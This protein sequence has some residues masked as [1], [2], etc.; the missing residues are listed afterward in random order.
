[1]KRKHNNIIV[2]FLGL[3]LISIVIIKLI[4]KHNDSYWRCIKA[5]SL[6]GLFEYTYF[7]QNSEYS[8]TIKKMIIDSVKNNSDFTIST[9]DVIDSVNKQVKLGFYVDTLFWDGY[10]T[11]ERNIFAI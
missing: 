9:I 10:C 3:I 6:A 4:P 5:K 1:M 8:D 2:G 11:R 7:N